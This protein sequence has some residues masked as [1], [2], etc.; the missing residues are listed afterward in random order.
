MSRGFELGN[1]VKARED[2]DSADN[3]WIIGGWKNYF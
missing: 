2:G 3:D 1:F